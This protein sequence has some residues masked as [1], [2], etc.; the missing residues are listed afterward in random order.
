MLNK[1]MKLNKGDTIGI[2]SP[3]TPITSICPKRFQRGKQYLESKG[4]KI[5]EGT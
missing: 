5:I 4:F 2:F 3:S 1:F